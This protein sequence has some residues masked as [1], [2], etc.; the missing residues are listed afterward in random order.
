MFDPFELSGEFFEGL[1]AIDEAIVERA[2]AEPCRD[3][4]GPLHRGDYP[5]KP[6]GGVIVGGRVVRPPLQPL[7]RPRGMPP[8][9]DAAV[10][11]VPGPTSVRRGRG[12]RGER[13]RPDD[14]GGERGRTGD[15]GSGPY[16]ASVAALVARPVHDEQR[17]SWSCR[18]GWC[19]P[20]SA[21]GCPPRCSSDSPSIRPRPSRSSWRGWRRS[22]RPAAPTDRAC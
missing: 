9:G 8:S 17:R 11:S 21:A 12:D 22:P 4:G 10:G 14:D 13:D 7:L 6:R 3:C 1:A 5:R 18:R 16:N 19:P 20:P 2:A 15:R